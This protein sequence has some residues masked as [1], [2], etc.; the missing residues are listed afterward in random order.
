MYE[1]ASVREREAVLQAVRVPILLAR[2]E[3]QHALLRFR[4]LR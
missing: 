2:C 3:A 4:S 1:S